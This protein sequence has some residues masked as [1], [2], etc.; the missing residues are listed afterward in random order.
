MAI[1][2]MREKGGGEREKHT[3][4]ERCARS[5]PLQTSKVVSPSD[6]VLQSQVSALDITYLTGERAP[7]GH[8]WAAV[9]ESKPSPAGGTRGKKGEEQEGKG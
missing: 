9:A 4:K 6:P 2:A 8:A 7:A 1:E 3:Q 5:R